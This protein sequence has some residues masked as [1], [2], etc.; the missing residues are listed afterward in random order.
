MPFE[1]RIEAEITAPIRIE[2]AMHARILSG[3]RIV[4]MTQKSLISPGPSILKINNHPRIRSGVRKPRIHETG[5]ILL[6][7]IN[8]VTKLINRQN[9]S[10]PLSTLAL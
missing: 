1:I 2:I 3:P 6:F 4:P 9:P 10:H 7:P 8:C 5:L